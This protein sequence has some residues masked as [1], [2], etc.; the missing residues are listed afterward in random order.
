MGK[1]IGRRC[2]TKAGADVLVLTT[3]GA[4][5]LSKAL[6]TDRSQVNLAATDK[7]SSLI[8]ADIL[9]YQTNYGWQP[10]IHPIGRKLIINVP[11]IEGS[12][13][14]QYVMNT[15]HGAWTK[16]TGWNANCF[17]AL[18]DDLYFGG[19]GV[20]YKCDTGESD[21]GDV[22]NAVCQQAFSYFGTK[23]QKKFQMVRPIFLT[24]GNLRP[25]IVMN[26]DFEQTRTTVAPSFSS[27]G[28]SEWDLSDW[29]TSD[30][31]SGDNIRKN[32]QS[33]TG[34]GYSGGIR[35]VT[36]TENL[37]CRWQSTDVL[38]EVGGVL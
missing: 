32:W 25:A 3:D 31:V 7:I 12:D 6:L 21:D 24:N 18:G 5:P 15:N 10:I 26:T 34:V 16:F 9:S 36:Q 14:I 1:P 8:N 37:S 19:D 38:F 13:A 22:I 33:V 2:F 30:W 35:M 4:F 11:R 29:D 27:A 28:G 17:E 20:V 23:Q